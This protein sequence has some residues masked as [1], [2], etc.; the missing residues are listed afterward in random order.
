VKLPELRNAPN[1]FGAS[2]SASQGREQQSRQD[3]NYSDHHK[4]LDEGEGPRWLPV[5]A[6]VVWTF[7]APFGHARET[8]RAAQQLRCDGWFVDPSQK[9]SGAIMRKL[10]IISLV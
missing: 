4:K 8:D 9:L 10:F 2:H 7:A 5:L 3:P 1:G 6:H